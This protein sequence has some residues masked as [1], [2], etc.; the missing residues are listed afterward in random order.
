MKLFALALL[1]SL[2]AFAHPLDFLKQGTK[3]EDIKRSMPPIA[4]RD[5]TVWQAEL[6][7]CEKHARTGYLYSVWSVSANQ[8]YLRWFEKPL[9]S[10]PEDQDVMY[11]GQNEFI[12]FLQGHWIVLVPEKPE[13]ERRYA[14][15]GAK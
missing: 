3:C 5:G 10:S 13:P 2:T 12:A 14:H 9:P 4:M 15:A 6:T 1:G 11:V 7:I 8:P